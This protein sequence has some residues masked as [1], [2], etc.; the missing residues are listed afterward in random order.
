MVPF[1]LLLLGCLQT[2]PSTTELAPAP[3]RTK[4]RSVGS[5][6]AKTGEP[7]LVERL[8]AFLAALGDEE[9]ELERLGRSWQRTL[10]SAK[11]SRTTRA[12]AA[13]RIE[14]EL[15]ELAKTLPA[16]DETRRAELAR[17]ILRIDED[18]PEANAVLGRERGADGLWRDAEERSWHASE[19]RIARL[20]QEARALEF[21]IES[22][23]S[24]NP[25]LTVAGGGHVVRS[26]GIE[27]HGNLP[28]GALERILRQGLRAA[29]YSNALIHGSVG[30]PK[31][32]PHRFVFLAS[33]EPYAACR[34]EAL[35]NRGLTEE[36]AREVERLD[37]RSFLDARGWRLS[38]WR[39]EADFEALVLWSLVDD[40]LP[41]GAQP[42]L[43]V[44]HV[45]SVCLRFLGTSGP[46]SVWSEKATDSSDQRSSAGTRDDAAQRQTL[47][48]V[49]RSTFHG[50][51]SWLVNAE[52]E[53][54]AP[55]WARAMLDQE[56]KIVDEPLLKATLVCEY[57]H[58]TERLAEL[59]EGT[60]ERRDVPA[61]IEAALGEPL[62][63]FEQRFRR[64]L[65]PPRE[66]S[67]AG[68]LRA[69]PSNA[70]ADTVSSD[71]LRA[72]SQARANA[73][74]GTV[75]EY[76]LVTLDEEL[77][78]NAARHAHYLALNPEQHGR[79]PD[80]H[81]EYAD[82][83]GFSPEGSLAGLS[84]VIAFDTAPAEAIDAWLGTFYHR[85][86]LL[87]PGLIGAGF[88]AE[89][90]VVV[91]DVTSLVLEPWRDHVALWPMEDAVDVP[92]ACG[93][94]V[95]NPVP[96]ETLTELGYPVTIQLFFREERARVALN[97]E[98]F[99][100]TPEPE[101]LVPCHVITPDAPLFL[102]LAPENAW[103]LLPAKHL[104]ANTL[105][106]ARARWL[107]QTR[108]WKFTTAK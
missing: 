8:R 44:G 1:A 22:E 59:L 45:N 60:K 12:S 84:S 40:W 72:L 47:W 108:T 39:T 6:V 91:L 13:R 20:E 93:A 38:R 36:A 50:C 79:W 89:A 25:A 31:L 61:A 63:D 11:P 5:E 94:E 56:G 95:P 43:R 18:Q 104:A 24:T 33:D 2:T 74:K 76:P 101:N 7:E 80:A 81:E 54:R 90:G 103:G 87:H 16:L 66:W 10:E 17:W 82:R 97:L 52:R 85:L 102:E 57:L 27:I 62:P 23:T 46:S 107:G 55:A 53:G 65:D 34:V 77:S 19:V 98:L 106:T 29:A 96:G 37:M 88:G 73:H 42:C 64:W 92:R 71:V 49:A 86:P 69:E 51:R 68:R 99:R 14:R 105:Y 9:R 78:R 15:P 48:R 35:T 100:G 83:P 3:L 32:T 28:L 58:V 70:V 41:R 4:W 67:V 21:S 26:Q 75:L 30:L